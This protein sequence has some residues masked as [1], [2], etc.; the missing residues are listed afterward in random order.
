MYMLY[1]LTIVLCL[2][3]RIAFQESSQTFLTATHRI[4]IA[5]NDDQGTFTP[6]RQRSEFKSTLPI[7][8]TYYMV[9]CSISTSLGNVTVAVAPDGLTTPP[10][11]PGEEVEMFSLILVDQNSLEGKSIFQFILI[12]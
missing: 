2:F 11:S 1:S 12:N 8:T 7:Y 10:T 6:S 4:D 5:S 9:L 3:R